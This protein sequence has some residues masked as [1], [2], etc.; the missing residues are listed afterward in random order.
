M[1]QHQ[2]LI[3]QLK[4]VLRQS[5]FDALFE[6]VTQQLPRTERFLLKMELSRLN[7]SSTQSIDLRHKVTG[8]CEQVEVGGVYHFLTPPLEEQLRQLVK[9]YGER[10]TVGAVEDLLAS[11]RKP[12]AYAPTVSTKSNVLGPGEME[13]LAL[14]YYVMRKEMRRTFSTEITVWQN[15]NEKFLGITLDLSI[16]GCKIRTETDFHLSPKLPVFIQFVALEKEFVIPT[17]EQGLQYQLLGTEERKGY[18]YLRLRRHNATPEQDQELE[19]VLQASSLR[20]VPEINHLLATTR[21]H[22]YE[23]HLLPTLRCISIA[24]G[25]E[26]QPVKLKPLLALQTQSNQQFFDYWVND[27]AI[28]QLPS[29]LTE[30]RITALQQHADDP[31]HSVIFSF[32]ILQNNQKLFF[33]ATL[34]ELQQV[35]MVDAFLQVAAGQ[36]SFRIHQIAQHEVDKNDLNRA[37]R[38]PINSRPFEP[39]VLQL[40]LETR[41]VIT[42]QPLD[43]DISNYQ[44]RTAQ[45]DPNLLRQYG[46]PRLQ[47]N[48]I[49]TVATKHFDMRREARYNFNTTIQIK[50]GFNTT[51]AAQ[52]VDLSSRGMKVKL[53]QK[54]PFSQDKPVD[55]DFPQLQAMAGKI[56]MAGIQYNIVGDGD[57]GTVLRLAVVEAK[58]YQGQRFITELLTKNSDRLMQTG[59]SKQNHQLIE[60]IKNLTLPRLPGLP[61]FIHKRHNQLLPDLLGCSN[62]KMPLLVKLNPDGK[63]PVKLNW[64][65]SYEPIVDLI[66]EV[67]KSEPLRSQ[68]LQ[69]AI[70]LPTETAAAEFRLVDK[71]NSEDLRKFML[72][73]IAKKRLLGLQID[74]FTATEPDL[75]YLQADLSAISGHALHRARELEK[76]L[77]QVKGCG[78]FTDITDELLCRTGLE[79]LL[80]KRF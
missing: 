1:E 20:T 74:L 28:N 35:K 22:G 25:F 41:L 10:L 52:T 43:T 54:N 55:V 19:H 45:Q 40:L 37:L 9:L 11:V 73:T 31:A 61:F 63:T 7:Q 76:M 39:L 79:A 30:K 51:I 67:V 42:V 24:Y 33:T 16:G 38:N 34:A 57:D 62:S 27:Q 8:N 26:G 47:E 17:L 71:T 53:E 2:A 49:R 80:P 56:K 78:H 14:G 23:R 59:S 12:Q 69:L 4:P 46:M 60:G 65:L 72:V 21:S 6:R 44:T 75:E 18:Q 66:D 13:M 32:H 70:A 3:E 68:Q 50:Q 48:A 36:P 58:T 5:N 29:V 64:L 15:S 77:W